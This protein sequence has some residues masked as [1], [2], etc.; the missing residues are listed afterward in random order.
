MLIDDIQPEYDF[1]EVHSIRVQATAEETF[2]GIKEITPSEISRIMQLLMWLRGLPE[3]LMGRDWLGLSGEGPL[4]AQMT[5]GGFVELAESAPNEIVLGMIAPAKL[6]RFWRNS[7]QPDVWCE[8]AQDFAAFDRPEYLKVVMNLTVEE[9]S[10]PGC[11]AIR[12]ETRC[13]ALSPQ[14]RKSFTPYWRLIRPYSGL[15]RIVWLRGIRRRVEK[16]A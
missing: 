14:A 15:I 5:S 4:L 7:S 8:N 2:K 6:G 12:T 11:V 13:R 16:Q 10:E 3:K 1:A 9:S